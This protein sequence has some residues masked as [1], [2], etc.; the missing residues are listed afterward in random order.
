MIKFTCRCF[1][2]VA[3]AAA[4]FVS[5]PLHFFPFI[6][7]FSNFQYTN[8]WSIWTIAP[9]TDD[10]L[11]EHNTNNIFF[12]PQF[13][14]LHTRERKQKKNHQQHNG[15]F[16]QRPKMERTR[17]SEKKE[18]WIALKIAIL[19]LAG[20]IFRLVKFWWCYL[21]SQP[22]ALW[23]VCVWSVQ[24]AVFYESNCFVAFRY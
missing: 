15:S 24:N 21:A 1:F 2:F 5:M 3:T 7:F 16:T 11:K 23:A 4:A 18:S 9:H 13:R 17:E 6:Y 12:C 19:F 10:A 20:I 14:W 8:I 22:L